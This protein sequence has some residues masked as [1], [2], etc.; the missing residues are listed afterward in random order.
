M[1]VVYRVSNFE[2]IRARTCSRVR[3]GRFEEVCELRREMRS[4]MH[5]VGS[6]LETLRPQP[7][8]KWVSDYYLVRN[9]IKVQRVVLVK[10]F[11]KTYQRQAEKHLQPKTN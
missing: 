10:L 11:E 6:E 7:I 9:E 1:R 2:R 5:I 3:S 8:I 4:L